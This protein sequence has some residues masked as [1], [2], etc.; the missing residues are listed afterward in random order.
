MTGQHDVDPDRHASLKM[1]DLRRGLYPAPPPV[2]GDA[3]RGTRS[4]RPQTRGWRERR[5]AM[6]WL[7]ATHASGALTCGCEPD[8]RDESRREA[9]P[10]ISPSG[11]GTKSVAV[12]YRDA[13]GELVYEHDRHDRPGYDRPGAERRSHH[14]SERQRLV[15]RRRDGRLDGR[16][17]ALRPRRCRSWRLD[18]HRRGRQPLRRGL[19]GRLAGNTTNASV[20][21]I[22][23]DRTAPVVTGTADRQG[24]RRRLEQQRRDRDLEGRR[25]TL[26]LR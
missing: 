24:Q 18:H 26:G 23:I 25:R 15:Q 7:R 3:A 4:P 16:R 22:K 2:H 17:R 21:P 8:N 19:G 5:L 11:D 13:A 10:L 12:Q 20:G 6:G 1:P 14:G 9:R